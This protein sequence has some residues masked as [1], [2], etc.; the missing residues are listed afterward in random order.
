MTA[1]VSLVSALLPASWPNRAAVL[2]CAAQVDRRLGITALDDF[3]A[4]WS[5]WRETGA[6]PTDSALRVL[7]PLLHDVITGGLGPRPMPSARSIA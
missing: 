4:A 3:L 5:A 1:I 2:E 7:L 6:M